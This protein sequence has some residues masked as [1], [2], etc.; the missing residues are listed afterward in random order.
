MT[1]AGEQ[2]AGARE[3]PMPSGCLQE[4]ESGAGP[5]WNVTG[6]CSSGMTLKVSPLP[7]I[8]SFPKSKIWTRSGP[9]GSRRFTK[10]TPV[11]ANSSTIWWTPL[12]SSMS[13]AMASAFRRLSSEICLRTMSAGSS[14]NQ[15]SPARF[16]TT[17]WRPV[18][19]SRMFADC[20]AKPVT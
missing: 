4:R 13:T 8:S 15:V 19:K 14:W 3:C 9:T 16:P 5:S 18:P 17:G 1:G 11:R 6:C 10:S 7:T 12:T 20:G 2:M